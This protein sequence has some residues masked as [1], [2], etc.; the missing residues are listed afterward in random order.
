[1]NGRT[2]IALLLLALVLLLLSA[3]NLGQTAT[4]P[5]ENPDLIYTQIW[6]T[7]AAAQTQTA[8]VITPTS[9]LTPTPSLSPTAEASHTPLLSPTS[10]PGTP[11]ATRVVVS[12]PGGSQ[13]TCD[14]MAYTDANLPDNS[15]VTAGETVIKTWTF[16]NLGPCEWNSGYRMIYVYETE[17]A[18]WAGTPPVSFPGDVAVGDSVDLSVTLEVP[19]TPGGYCAWFRLENDKW[20]TI[21]EASTFGEFFAVCLLAQ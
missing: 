18:G 2:K 13:S 3:C 17:G 8:L 15:K 20:P 16:K 4:T 6:V 5:T 12:N 10:L 14:N 21:G 19:S 11:S 7:V 1:M 9:S